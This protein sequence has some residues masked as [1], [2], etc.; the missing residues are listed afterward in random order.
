[1]GMY[2]YAVDCGHKQYFTAPRNYAI[3][4]PGIFHPKNPFPGMVVMKNIQGFNFEIWDD[5]SSHIPPEEGYEEITESVYQ[6]YLDRF[7]D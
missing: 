3:K 1:M 4:S 5:F 6:E 2:Y 7:K